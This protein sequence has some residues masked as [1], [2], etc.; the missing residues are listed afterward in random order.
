MK[1]LFYFTG[2]RLSVLHWKGKQL[3]GTSSFEP[4]DAGLEKFRAYLT[5]TEKISSRFLVDVIEEDFRN[6]RIPHVGARDRNAVMNRLLDRYYRS[7]KQYCYST[8]IGREKS[9]RKDDIVLL[10]AMTNPHLIQPWLTII[11]ECEVPLSGIWTLPIISKQLL[12]TIKA[13]SGVVLL[14][15]QQ[16]NSN[17]RQTLF[18][19]GKL[20]SSRQSIINQDINDIS[21]IGELAAPEVKRTIEFLR[22]QGLVGADELI[23]LHILG[24]DEQLLSLQQSFIANEQQTVTIHRIAE[25]HKKLGLKDVENKFSD[26]IFAWYCV[27]QGL[28]ISH[29]GERQAFNRYH[30]KLAAT[31]LY[32]ASLA[33]LITGALLAQSNLSD[34]VEYEKSIALLK[35]EENTYKELYSKKF[36]EFEEVFQNAGV[37]NSA[38]ELAEQIKRNSET[39]PLDFLITLSNI[40]SNDVSANIQIDKIEWSAINIEEKD[41]RVSKANFTG[42]QPVKHDAVVTG[43]IDIPENEYRDSIQQ[44]QQI[45][46]SLSA[47]SR[48]EE[49]VALKMPVDLRSESKFSTE[50]GVDIKR[51]NNSESTGI[52]SLRVTMKAPDHV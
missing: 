28:S 15:S 2:Y 46:D 22:A 32:V 7:S 20:I 48:V 5:N 40:I 24:S 9:G 11:D 14:V 42:K 39:S 13:A 35:R 16:V 1:R 30:N 19:D 25:L 47:S 44:I 21:G 43:R 45:I 33:V 52:F 50:S 6:E 3:L 27:A 29:Y 51:R 34:A 38:V 36:E 41:G 26:G 31:A 4:T 49:V 10:G 17:V 37:M 12:K 23:N 18:R 8:V